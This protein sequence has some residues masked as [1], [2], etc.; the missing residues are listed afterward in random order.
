MHPVWL[1]PPSC[2]ADGMLEVCPENGRR[3]HTENR[4]PRNAF[5]S[6]IWRAMACLL[7]SCSIPLLLSGCG[8]IAANNQ[9]ATPTSTVGTLAVSSA[10]LS[11]GS[12]SV[13]QSASATLSLSNSGQN[14]VQVSQIN[15]SGQFFS[16]LPAESPRHY[17]GRRKSQR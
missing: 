16:G 9:A 12:V 2:S 11:F 15:V 4:G 7:A 10:S 3:R 6:R 8:S 17:P 14:S 13:G 1:P 5:N